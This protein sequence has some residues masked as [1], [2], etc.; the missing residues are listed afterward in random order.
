MCKQTPNS[1]APRVAWRGVAMR[2]QHEKLSTTSYVPALAD[3]GNVTLLGNEGRGDVGGDVLVALLVT[4]VLLDVLE[5]VTADDDGALHLGGDDE[6]LDDAA[7]DGHVASEGA[8]LVNVL[9]GDGGLRDLE[10]EA[11]VLHIAGTLLAITGNLLAGGTIDDNLPLLLEG[12]LGLIQSGR[13]CDGNLAKAIPNKKHKQKTPSK[14][15][16]MREQPGI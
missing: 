12:A 16:H 7:T 2:V 4:T 15:K 10:G 8:L 11:D 13:H 5:V 6:T 14:H 1:H 9:A 3:G